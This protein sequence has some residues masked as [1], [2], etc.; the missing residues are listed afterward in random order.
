MGQDEI[1]V[2]LIEDDEEDAML[3]GEML[4]DVQQ[5]RFRLHHARRL[6]EGLQ[7]LA[8][9]R[10]DLVLLDLGLPDSWGLGSLDSILSQSPDTPVVVL[11]LLGDEETPL[12][13]VQHGAQDYLVK[14]EFR[15]ELLG[16]CLRHAIER[17][18]AQE[19]LRAQTDALAAG[20]ERLSA[21]LDALPDAVLVLGEDRVVRFANAAAEDLLGGPERGLLGRALDLPLQ[22]GRQEVAPEGRPAFQA[23]VRLADMTWDDQPA[24]LIVLTAAGKP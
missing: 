10:P 20:R 16:R 1:Q 22:P 8:Q 12:K 18:R 17:Q 15:G 19:A 6:S 4:A 24:R 11:T 21:V 2:L 9:R 14:G 13:A 5:A 23:E 7:R 3:I